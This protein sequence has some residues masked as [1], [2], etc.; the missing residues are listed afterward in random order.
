MTVT[1]TAL[2][3]KRYSSSSW[4][5]SSSGSCSKDSEAAA[6]LL[7]TGRVTDML[8]VWDPALMLPVSSESS[9]LSRSSTS[10]R[11]VEASELSH[12]HLCEAGD[13]RAPVS[14]SAGITT[15]A[16]QTL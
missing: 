13:I 5:S 7:A 3:S 15:A 11:R 9:S 14:L 6:A 1:A 2:G 10:K 4:I 16:E 8:S 12:Q